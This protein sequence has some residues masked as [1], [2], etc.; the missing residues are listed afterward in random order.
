MN[1][2]YRGVANPIYI[3]KPNVVSFEATA[4]GLKKLDN[5]GNYNLNVGTGRTIDITIKSKL[6]NGDS[7]TE[8]KTLRIKD[9]SVPIGTI[10]GIGCGNK[11]ELKLKKEEMTDAIIKAE[12]KN[13]VHDL[14]LIVASFKIKMPHY[15]VIKINGNKMN[16]RANDLFTLL[17]PD[18]II[19][20]FDIKSYISGSSSYRLKGIA[21]IT[22][23]IIE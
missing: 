23:R 12:V 4:F 16:V 11:C 10:N 20:I 14:D 7:L 6:K 22:I 17:R 13:F 3:S 18:D 15:R 2:V 19:E 21:P 5:F 1:V 9:I 8:I